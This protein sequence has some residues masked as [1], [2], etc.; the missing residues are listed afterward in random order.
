MLRIATPEDTRWL[1][2]KNPENLDVERNEAERLREALQLNHSL[3]T[4]YYLKEDLRQLWDQADQRT[5][6]KFLDGWI[7]RAEAS[8]IKMLKQFAR[9]LASHRAGLLAWY[10]YQI[11]TGPLEAT[12]NTIQLLKRQA[13][14]YRDHEFFKLKIYALH[15]CRYA[16]VG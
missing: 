16:L 13:F 11:S 9:T 3:V 12:N 2:L 8:G 15:L 14:G 4:A 1:L 6:G 5:A 7:R 10:D